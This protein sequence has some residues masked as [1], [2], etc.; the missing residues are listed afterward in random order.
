MHCLLSSTVET[1]PRPGMLLK[2][3]FGEW[4]VLTKTRLN[5]VTE[6]NSCEVNADVYLPGR[7]G[8]LPD[9]I[10]W[11]YLL[12]VKCHCHCVADDDT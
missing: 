8:P 3:V 1:E 5:S 9:C 12:V 10:S 2:K 7:L 11:N 6:V 4:G